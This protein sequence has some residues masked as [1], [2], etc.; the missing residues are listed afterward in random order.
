MGFPCP[1]RRE[2]FQLLESIPRANVVAGRAMC[3][4]VICRW[5]FN[6]DTVHGSV[7]T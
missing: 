1:T 2:R 3:G 7:R 6:L 4:A 5:C